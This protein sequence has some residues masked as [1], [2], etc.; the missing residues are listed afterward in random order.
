M[1]QDEPIE[2]TFITKRQITKQIAEAVLKLVKISDKSEEAA[3][4][5]AGGAIN[6]ELRA[7]LFESE[8][9]EK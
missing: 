8:V 5:A 1:P 2:V 4:I 3:I 7:T 6:R 9:N